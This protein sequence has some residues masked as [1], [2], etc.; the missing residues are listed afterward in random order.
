MGWGR[1]TKTENRRASRGPT[2]FTKNGWQSSPRT[3]A[4]TPRRT[5]ALH[6]LRRFSCEVATPR[7]LTS[8]PT[9]FC[10]IAKDPGCAA[11]ALL[12]LPSCPHK[13]PRAHRRLAPPHE[14]ILPPVPPPYSTLWLLG[15][16]VPCVQPLAMPS[17]SSPS[18]Q[19]PHNSTQ[20]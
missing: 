10:P 14:W 11:P 8:S 3:P 1:D 7:H 2:Q 13:G 9:H 16:S 19:W 4:R 6:L 15:C 18:S 12:P 5:N 20:H 17:A